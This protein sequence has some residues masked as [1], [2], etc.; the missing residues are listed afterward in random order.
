MQGFWALLNNQVLIVS[1]FACFLTQGIK[2]LVESIRLGKVDYHILVSTGGMPSSH[3]ALVA[4]MAASVGLTVGWGSTQ[5][6]IATL[7]AVIVTFDATGIRQ[8][9]GQQAQVL[10][11]IVDELLPSNA[12]FQEKRLKELLGHTPLQV[13]VGISLGVAIAFLAAPLY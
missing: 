6:A 1:L 13:V 4:A 10:N 11:L 2:F 12:S 3:S 7:V 8:A 5:F 9:A